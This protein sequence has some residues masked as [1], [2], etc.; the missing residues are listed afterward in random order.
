MKNARFMWNDIRRKFQPLT[1]QLLVF[2][3][4]KV[5]FSTCFKKSMSD[6]FGHH[7]FEHERFPFL[8]IL[9]TSI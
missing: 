1:F 3:E 2:S 4:L 7:A 5:P 8:F 9:D 6:M